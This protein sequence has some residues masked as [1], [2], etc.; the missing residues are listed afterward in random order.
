MGKKKQAEMNAFKT[1]FMCCEE[2]TLND[3]CELYP[4]TAERLRWMSLRRYEEIHKI[5]A[6]KEE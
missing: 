5:V 6:K 1:F 4:K 2:G 3:L